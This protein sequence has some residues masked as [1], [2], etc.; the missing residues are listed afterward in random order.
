M[1]D[2]NSR[3]TAPPPLIPRDAKVPDPGLAQLR[4][5]LES[6]SPD[7]HEDTALPAPPVATVRQRKTFLQR[8]R[9]TH[10]AL[11]SHQR[12]LSYRRR[13]DPTSPNASEKVSLEGSRYFAI[14]GGGPAPAESHEDWQ[15]WHGEK[16]HEY[17]S[18][19]RAI[20]AP[21]ADS[22]KVAIPRQNMIPAVESRVSPIVEKAE[23]PQQRL[24]EHVSPS[25]NTRPLGPLLSDQ[26]RIGPAPDRPLPPLPDD[27]DRERTMS[28]THFAQALASLEG[29]VSYPKP[30]LWEAMEQLSFEDAKDRGVEHD[31]PASSIAEPQPTP[32][33][34]KYPEARVRRRGS[35]SMFL[36]I[37]D[38][39]AKPHRTRIPRA[40]PSTPVGVFGNETQSDIMSTGASRV[41]GEIKDGRKE[42]TRARKLRDIPT[43]QKHEVQTAPAHENISSETNENVI[44]GSPKDVPHASTSCG[45]TSSIR[46]SQHH[47][48]ASTSARTT[49]ES[50]MQQ[51]RTSQELSVRMQSLQQENRMLQAALQ[52]VLQT[53]GQVN[54]CPFV[55][56]ADM[57]SARSISDALERMRQLL[58]HDGVLQPGTTTMEPG[59]PSHRSTNSTDSRRR[60]RRS[61]RSPSALDLYL[62]TRRGN[63]QMV[64]DSMQISQ[65]GGG[66]STGGN[67]SLR[68]DHQR[69][70]SLQKS[71][72]V[73][74]A[75]YE[76]EPFDSAS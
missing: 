66:S 25:P 18:R 36:R 76:E 71:N 27:V 45:A 52:A 64:R 20:P 37:D 38:I 50:L 11:S 30:M 3:R 68:H 28:E 7:N 42:R 9:K 31:I 74:G 51:S 69:T 19:S 8:L 58:V 73:A 72:A 43:T 15:P 17:D 29:A 47:S 63:A 39:S 33:P 4:Y 26:A 57:S 22:Q 55:N 46:N 44:D 59:S 21:A 6:S 48:S 32:L 34:H 65:N 61:G 10:T 2:P 13:T 70:A 56:T 49:G 1:E 23:D 12:S 16:T 35:S 75:A 40:P 67:S 53:N 54:G 60:R 62:A 24:P 5:F 41:P 14:L